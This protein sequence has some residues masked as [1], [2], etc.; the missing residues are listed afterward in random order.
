MIGH[1]SFDS[2]SY[3]ESL[4]M[5]LQQFTTISK[6]KN[7]KLTRH[8]LLDKMDL[9]LMVYVPQPSFSS[10]GTLIPNTLMTTSHDQHNETILQIISLCWVQNSW[11]EQACYKRNACILSNFYQKTTKYLHVTIQMHLYTSRYLDMFDITQIVK[12]PRFLL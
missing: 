10:L 11:D 7:N 9:V 3:G 1:L 2:N 12:M 4:A 6:Q 8:Q 5:L